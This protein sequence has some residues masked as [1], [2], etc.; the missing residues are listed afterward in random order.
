MTKIINKDT[1]PYKT[2]L[3][4]LENR[5]GAFLTLER[6]LS[7]GDIAVYNAPLSDRGEGRTVQW[8]RQ[9]KS[10]APDVTSVVFA[11][12]GIKEAALRKNAKG[13]VQRLSIRTLLPVF[14][15]DEISVQAERSPLFGERGFDE[16]PRKRMFSFLLTGKDDVGVIAQ[17]RREIALAE[18]RAK[19]SFIDAMLAPLEQRISAQSAGSE[20]QEVTTI[21]RVDDA[22]TRLSSALAEN[23]EARV[24]LRE[25]RL[26]AVRQQQQAETQI[27][28]IEE[29]IK[30]YRL[31]S[32]RYISDLKRL[33]FVAEGT[34]FFKDLQM[35]QCPLCDQPLGPEHVE[36]FK[37]ETVRSVYEAARAEAAKI[38]GHRAELAI[39][40]RN[41]EEVLAGWVGQ[42]DDAARALTRIELQVNRD[43]GPRLR[44][45]RAGLDELISR[46]V[47]LESVKSEQD[48]AASLRDKRAEFEK[49]LDDASGSTPKKWAAIE[50]SELRAFCEEVEDVLKNWGW[51]D[52]VRVEFDEG[53]PFDIRIDGKPRQSHGKGYRAILHAAFAFGLLHYC[54]RHG[55]PHPGFLVINSPL[56]PFKKTEKKNRGRRDRTERRARVLGQLGCHRSR[57]SDR[58]ARKQGA[59]RRRDV[60]SQLHLF[61]G[62]N[63][64]LGQRVGFIPSGSSPP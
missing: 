8:K 60:R 32:Q 17:E 13:E 52:T 56:T 57:Y 37:E 1:K 22:I 55:T 27:L 63:A 40:L 3:L 50:P 25:E 34:Y 15:V 11:F 51:P 35:T 38:H 39:A 5:E 54:Q 43:L 64:G 4:E 16:T 14:V 10:M 61:C 6:H 18:I 2:V 26:E 33:D 46:R 20:A 12:C 36:H 47:A 48:Q 53:K 24:K 31:L 41:L 59:A 7:G 62:E 9:G 44:D 42:R 58:R 30:R 23:Q 21:E 45:A 28:A 29:L 19:L 49:A